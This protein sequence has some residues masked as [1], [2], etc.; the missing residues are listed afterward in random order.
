MSRAQ[1]YNYHVRRLTLK[2]VQMIRSLK[3]VRMLSQID[4]LLISRRDVH[5]VL[6]EHWQVIG[7]MMVVVT[8]N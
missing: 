5:L 8:R 4:V 3:I 1:A 2:I 7:L 6:Q